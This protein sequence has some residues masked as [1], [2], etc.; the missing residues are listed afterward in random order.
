M[1]LSRYR[2]ALLPIGLVL[3]MAT[4]RVGA[5]ETKSHVDD[6]LIADT[7]SATCEVLKSAIVAQRKLP[8]DT[9]DKYQWFCDFAAPSDNQYLRI[10]AL[11]A[12]RCDAASCLMG[13]FAVMRQSSVVL[14]WDVGNNRIVPLD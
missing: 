5:T 8:L 7:E 4:T 2:H 3:S 14:Q 6:P 13:W 9:P 1:N 12:G 11:R 10:V